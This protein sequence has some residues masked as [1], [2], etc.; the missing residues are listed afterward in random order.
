[1]REWTTMTGRRGAHRKTKMDERARAGSQQQAILMSA[2][3]NG[4]CGCRPECVQKFWWQWK[5]DDD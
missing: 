5:N 3:R 2:A 4:V 1:M